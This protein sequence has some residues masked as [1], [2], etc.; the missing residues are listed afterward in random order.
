[1]LLQSCKVSSLDAF[2]TIIDWAEVSHTQ[3][4]TM[5]NYKSTYG[6]D[7]RELDRPGIVPK[8]TERKPKYV[9]YTGPKIAA[10]FRLPEDLMQSLRLHAFKENKSISAVVE[11][12]LCS[13]QYIGKAYVS[14]RDAA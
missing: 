14:V 6:A 11:S 10:Q 3:G 1:M 4:M 9:K 2:V 8:S 7:S 13:E 5:D 12:C